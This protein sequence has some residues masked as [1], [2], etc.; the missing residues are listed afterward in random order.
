MTIRE[1]ARRWSK[2]NLQWTNR[3]RIGKKGRKCRCLRFR[4]KEISEGE[5]IRI[6]RTIAGCAWQK[7]RS[8]RCETDEPRL[9][10]ATN[11]SHDGPSLLLLT[12]RVYHTETE[13][14]SFPATTRGR[15]WSTSHPL[16]SIARIVSHHVPRV[17]NK[18]HL[19]L[20]ICSF[21]L[22]ERDQSWPLF[23]QTYSS[24][25]SQYPSHD[26]IHCTRST[27]K[28]TFRFCICLLFTVAGYREFLNISLLISLKRVVN[29]YR[30]Y[31]NT[32]NCRRFE[33][34]S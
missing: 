16:R 18:N 4:A 3:D 13:E 17:Q 6:Y 14:E 10:G 5:I 19:A 31:W 9:N 25:R 30:T 23:F 1:H 24:M 15:H 21:M 28:R 26:A 11:Q 32:G 2:I 12:Q 29:K 27:A 20:S 7:R 34:L 22:I 8:A 33:S